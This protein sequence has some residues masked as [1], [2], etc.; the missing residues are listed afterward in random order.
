V[1][2]ADRYLPAHDLFVSVWAGRVTRADCN[3]QTRRVKRDPL[4]VMARLRLTDIRYLDRDALNAGDLPPLFE[5]YPNA[6]RPRRQHLAIIADPG[7]PFTTAMDERRDQYPGLNSAVFNDL[8]GACDWLI[9][10]A[11]TV[12]TVAADLREQLLL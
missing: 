7:W 1:G 10:D 2:I 8:Y 12:I 3:A 5:I 11:D 4:Q 9:V 6:P